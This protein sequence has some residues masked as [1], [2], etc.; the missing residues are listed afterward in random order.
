MKI[1]L[2]RLSSMGDLIHTLPAITDLSH[3][4][5]DIELHWLCESAFADIARLH[6]F[7]KK[8]HIMSWRKWRKQLFQAATWQALGDLKQKLYAE[9]YNQVIDSQGLLKSA[10]FAKWGNAPISGLDKHSARESW[11]AHFYQQTVAVKKGEDA[12]WRN[13]QM[14]AQIFDYQIKTPPDFGV[15]LP[16]GVSGSLKDLPE[17]YHV[18]L[19]ATS[20]DSKLWYYDNWIDFFGKMHDYDGLPVLL[21]WG[22]DVEKQRAE[23]MARDLPFV[24]VCPRLT[25]LQATSLLA[26]AQSVVGVD[27]GLLHL[28][29]AVNRPLVGIYTDTDPIKT[30]VQTSKWAVNLGGVG[31]IP[32]AD[33]VFQQIQL[34]IKEFKN[35]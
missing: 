11:A 34:C 13:R 20:R 2:V 3:H 32:S 24:Q 19:H 10:I 25:L 22:N 26:Q 27:T 6:P 1:L 9:N 23:E 29:N 14:V 5:P 17:Y 33:V 35:Q 4:R 30:G 15:V 16:D 21:P 18:A 7:V 8:V 31:Q 12:V 28:A